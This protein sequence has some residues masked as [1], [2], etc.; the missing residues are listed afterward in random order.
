MHECRYG[1]VEPKTNTAFWKKKRQ[2][3]VD[4]DRKQLAR[5]DSEG[6]TSLVVWECETRDVAIL[7]QKLFRFLEANESKS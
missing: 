7:K 5:L 4:R 2:T 1:A 6:W 3:N